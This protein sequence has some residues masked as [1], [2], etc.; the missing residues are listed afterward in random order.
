MK[1]S[2]TS[3]P[4][5]EYLPRFGEGE[6]ADLTVQQ[7]LQMRS[8]IPFGESYKDPFG[9]QAKAYYRDDNRALLQPYRVEGTPG[10]TFHYQGG[11]TMLL[12]EMLDQVREGN[13][14]EDI[15]NGLWEQMGA[16]HDAF[17][18][19]MAT[20]TTGRWSDRL[21]S[22]MRRRETL[23]GLGNSSSTQEPGRVSNCFRTISQTRMIT[24]IGAVDR[25]G[26]HGFLRVSNLAGHHRRWFALLHAGR[27][28]VIQMVI[29]P[30]PTWTWSS[31]AQVTTSSKPRSATCPSTRTHAS[32]TWPA[33]HSGDGLPQ[34]RLFT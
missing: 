19:L 14:S 9:F 1:G 27:L 31:C 16:E 15:A 26:G 32:S 20:P 25:R 4:L 10:T 22:T 11:N 29:V 18:G 23:R 2:S 33:S 12:A 34:P 3:R 7:V 13:L 24:P 30:F 28:E 8:N 6:S 21:P 17:W 5:S